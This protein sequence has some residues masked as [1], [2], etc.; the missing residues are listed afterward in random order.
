MPSARPRYVYHVRLHGRVKV[1]QRRT[2]ARPPTPEGLHQN[3]P[4][5][6]SKQAPASA[7]GQQNHNNE[8]SIRAVRSHLSAAAIA[9]ARKILCGVRLP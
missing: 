1:N 5:I 8:V 3:R 6:H 4:K 7:T 9:G 2:D